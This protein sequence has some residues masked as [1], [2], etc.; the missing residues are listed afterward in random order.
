MVTSRTPFRISLFGG[1]TDYPAWW[2]RHGGSVLG[3]AI[4]KYCY[5]QLTSLPSAADGYRIAYAREE[6]VW[7]IGAIRHPAVRAVYAEEAV[8]PGLDMVHRSDLPARSG[9]GSSSSFVV[10]LVHALRAR[11]GQHPGQDWLAREAIRIEQDVIR[12]NVGCQDQIWAA[13]GGLNHIRFLPSGAIEVT[14]LS[15]GASRRAELCASILLVSTGLSRIASDIAGRQIENIARRTAQLHE[16]AGLVDEAAGWLA[17]ERRPAHCLGELLHHSWMLKRQLAAGIS[18]PT[19]DAIYEEALAAGASG[20][21][22]LGAGNGGF[23]A[24]FINPGR[25]Q[26]LARRLS[27]L[28]CVDIGIDDTGSTILPADC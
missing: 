3:M 22:L 8:G 11:S 23:L 16:M 25:R 15:L 12:E 10:G 21:K 4:D 18:N 13:H 14:P 17:D 28:K 27:R 6:H 20:G 19:I 2:R 24:F 9:L 7:S 26:D 1:G 5:I